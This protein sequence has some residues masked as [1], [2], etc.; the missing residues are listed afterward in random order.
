MHKSK[1][2]AP[3]PAAILLIFEKKGAFL[4]SFYSA[5]FARASKFHR[6]QGTRNKKEEAACC[7][8]LMLHNTR[9][10]SKKA[11]DSTSLMLTRA[12]SASTPR[13]PS[14]NTSN[15]SNKAA[16]GTSLATSLVNLFNIFTW[17]CCCVFVLTWCCYCVFV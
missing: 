9:N 12:Q 8:V 4:F 7:V 1:I 11:T 14:T 16:L 5:Q 15:T 3:Q 10:T 2:F 13:L 6:A 17:C